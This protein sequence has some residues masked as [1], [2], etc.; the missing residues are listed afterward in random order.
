MRHMDGL[1]RFWIGSQVGG[2]PDVAVWAPSQR[3]PAW[4][5]RQGRQGAVQL[6]DPLGAL[7]RARRTTSRSA[8]TS[9]AS[10]LRVRHLADMV[11]WWGGAP[12]SCAST[13]SSRAAPGARSTRRR[14]DA[15][16]VRRGEADDDRACLDRAPE[17]GVPYCY[18]MNDGWG[19]M[20]NSVSRRGCRPRS[21]D[22]VVENARDRRARKRDGQRDA[23]GDVRE[24][25]GRVRVVPRQFVVGRGAVPRRVQGGVTASGM[26]GCPRRRCATRAT[27][28]AAVSRVRP[29]RG[30]RM[31]TSRSARARRPRRAQRA[32]A[33]RA[34]RQTTT[35]PAAS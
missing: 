10:L 27:P 13:A 7:A 2:V 20:E 34:G 3:R 12:C 25:A 16:R 4:H 24:R 19:A 5:A 31:P 17:D 21:A 26:G 32:T 35:D 28:A 1:A 29:T 9:R 18:L 23:R 15:A 33:C 8:A 22:D 14:S 11:E 6:V 30:A